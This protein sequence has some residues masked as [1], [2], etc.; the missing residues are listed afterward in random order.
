MQPGDGDTDV[1]KP[2]WTGSCGTEGKDDSHQQ[3]CGPQSAVL[4]A[5]L[6]VV[7][8]SR[9]Q[10]LQPPLLAEEST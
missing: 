8:Y 5:E 6:A 2:G 4:S 3:R 1:H 9:A 10:C 7:T